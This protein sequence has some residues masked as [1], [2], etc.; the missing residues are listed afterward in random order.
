MWT[1]WHWDMLF[2]EPLARSFHQYYTLI[3]LSQ[4]LYNISTYGHSNRNCVPEI[5]LLIKAYEYCEKFLS[6]LLYCCERKGVFFL[7]VIPWWL[8]V[9]GSIAAFLLESS[10]W[11]AFGVLACRCLWMCTLWY[12]DIFLYTVDDSGET[13]SFLGLN[14]IGLH[15]FYFR[16]VPVFQFTGSQK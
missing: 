3:H 16:L 6:L 1:K 12:H 10:L 14:L 5:W 4:T 9:T 2:S 8:P 13:L 11:R 7:S 15:L